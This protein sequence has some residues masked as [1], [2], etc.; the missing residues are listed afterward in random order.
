MERELTIAIAVIIAS[1]LILL[2]AKIDEWRDAQSY[3]LPDEWWSRQDYEG[4]GEE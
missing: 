3:T 2:V 4:K 1:L